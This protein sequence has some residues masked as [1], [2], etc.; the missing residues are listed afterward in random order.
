MTFIKTTRDCYEKFF[1]SILYWIRLF[2]YKLFYRYS[3]GYNNQR[4]LQGYCRPSIVCKYIKNSETSICGVFYINCRGREPPI[5]C[6]LAGHRGFVIVS[7]LSIRIPSGSLY[8]LPSLP[9][10]SESIALFRRL[11]KPPILQRNVRGG[12][13]QNPEKN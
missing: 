4:S 8:Q 3:F 10:P 7:F 12:G 11:V 5:A 13:K 2:S 6:A 1:R 9:P